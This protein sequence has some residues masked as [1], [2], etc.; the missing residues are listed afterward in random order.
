MEAVRLDKENQRLQKENNRLRMQFKSQEEDR[1]E[2]VR[3]V[4]NC[5]CAFSAVTTLGGRC[6]H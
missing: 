5:S 1:D 3:Q 2:L 4:L 6:W